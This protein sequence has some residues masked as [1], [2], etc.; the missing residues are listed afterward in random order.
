MSRLP[1]AIDITMN[2][3]KARDT[4][5]LLLGMKYA[6]EMQEYIV[7]IKQVMADRKVSSVFAAS[8]LCNATPHTMQQIKILS[9]VVEMA[10]PSGVPG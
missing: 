10:E 4:A 3:Y 5:R 1:Q 2:L 7:L 9:A 6:A 8:I